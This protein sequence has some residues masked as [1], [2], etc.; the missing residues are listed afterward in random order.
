MGISYLLSKNGFTWF[1]SSKIK[2][3]SF[4][5]YAIVFGEYENENNALECS[6][7]TASS[8]GGAYIFEDVNYSVVGMI[9]ENIDDANMVMDNFSKDLTYT[10]IVKQFK[11]NKFS[12]LVD[13]IS[14]AHKKDID[15]AINLIRKSINDV[16]T[17]SNKVDTNVLSNVSASSEIN[18][19]KSEI[20]IT[21]SSLNSLN[22]AYN[23][24]NVKELSNYLTKAEDSLDVCINKLLTNENYSG[25]CKYCA[26]ELF[27]N[28]Y[29]LTKNIVK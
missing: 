29:N 28:F 14:P 22:S 8:G 26:C 19:I 18:S 7:W 12:F 13:N 4:N 2:V 20:K 6:I 17:I 21:K 3:D 23:N 10:P 9:Y 15:D 5:Y 25:V 27:F 24:V 11:S 1:K 16:L